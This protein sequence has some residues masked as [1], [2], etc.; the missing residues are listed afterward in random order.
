MNGKNNLEQDALDNFHDMA[1][2]GS[3]DTVNLVVEVGRPA[4]HY[5]L[6]DEGWSGVKRYLVKKGTKPIAADAIE[7]LGQT[8][9]TTDMG[10]P[11]TLAAFID[12]GM[13]RYPANRYF[14]VVW[15]HGQG[16]RFQLAANRELKIMAARDGMATRSSLPPTALQAVPPL[17]SF[18]SVSSDDDTGNVLYNSQVQRVIAEKF[19][20]KKIDLIGFDACLMAMIETAYAFRNTAAVM[21]ASEE[22][23]P[24]AGW[25]YDL[26]VKRLVD[27]PTMSASELGAAIVDSYQA[28]YADGQLTTLSVLDLTRIEALSKSLSTL[29]DL[30]LQHSSSERAF[31]S[32]ARSKIRAYGAAAGLRT[33]IDLGFFLDLYRA[34]TRNAQIRGA[35]DRMRLDLGSTVLRNYASALSKPKYGSRGLALYFPQNKADFLGDPHSGGYY[36]GNTQH[37]V[38]FVKKEK[39]ADFINTF[40]Q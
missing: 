2:V 4:S 12:W 19:R 6:A 7:D 23:E 40:L 35:I 9:P 25:P 21:I 3:S 8:G 29:S 32:D 22:L 27:Q 20:D 33:S 5:S 28:R 38:E 11:A 13:G 17:G 34:R 18:R 30:M 24:G 31:I 36:K 15:N 1:K 39:W 26:W 14:L 10:S 16:W 37:P